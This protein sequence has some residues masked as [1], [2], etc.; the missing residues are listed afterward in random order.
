MGTYEGDTKRIIEFVNDNEKVIIIIR[1]H[2]NKIK[3]NKS[4]KCYILCI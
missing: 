1:I 2:L 3:T 4:S